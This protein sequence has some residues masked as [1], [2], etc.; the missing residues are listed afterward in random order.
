MK[1]VD[2]FR[3]PVAARALAARLAA[4]VLPNRRYRFMEF[5][6]G[7]THAL[8]RHGVAGLLPPAIEM[9]HGP[10]CPVCVLPIGRI[11]QAIAL[12]C[13]HGVIVCTYGDTMRVPA[14]GG[15]SL[16]QARAE[17][18]DVRVVYSPADALQV[19]REQPAR[20][21]VL[22]AIGFETT[23]P[24]T[25]LALQAAAHEGLTNF[26][27]LCCHVL[28]PPAI[29]HVL[30]DVHVGGA[31]AHALDGLVGPGHVAVVTGAA[32][33]AR[34]AAAHG[35]PV[36]IAGFEPLDLLQAILR[37]VRQVNESRAEAENAFARAVTWQ[38]NRHAQALVD[39]VLE[40]RASFE[41]RGLGTLPASA[42]RPRAAY[43]ALD[44][45]R[46]FR[47][48]CHAVA[49]HPQCRCASVLRGVETPSQCRLFAT[50]CTPAHPL[51][52]CM[53]SSE[54]ACAAHYSRAARR[55]E[56]KR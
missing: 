27:V 43:A 53:V 4:D 23:T 3:D 50:A 37:L 21:V 8:A 49:D 25:A 39:A 13:D 15:R 30:D 51:G 52:A 11:D 32:P 41:W 54:G 44:A 34:I 33:F 20:E 1:Y 29:A 55:D 17:G 7:H 40:P 2:E 26:S 48:P 28:T 19:A 46:R 45:E 10:G 31:A 14:S 6:G 18:A 24:P 9:V 35:V 16:L 22:F 36:V 42:L 12:A 5:C 47:L 38:G 56:V